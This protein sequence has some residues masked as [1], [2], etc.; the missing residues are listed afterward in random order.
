[1]FMIPMPPTIS[2]MLA[3]EAQQDGEQPRILIGQVGHVGQ[4]AHEEVVILSG[5]DAVAVAQAER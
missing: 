4:V 2:E 5:A 3:I 1:M